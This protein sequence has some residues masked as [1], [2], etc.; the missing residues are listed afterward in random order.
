MVVKESAEE[1]RMW[2][3]AKS[4]SA[5]DGS[6][7]PLRDIF[8]LSRVPIKLA[9]A[10]VAIRTALCFLGLVRRSTDFSWNHV[11][12]LHWLRTLETLSTCMEVV[13]GIRS[14]DRGAASRA[15][16]SGLVTEKRSTGGHHAALVDRKLDKRTDG[17]VL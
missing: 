8:V 11:L 7:L 10:F 15:S 14:A 2:A 16:S 1:Q 17:G 12:T 13:R 4:A 5:D 9:L 3:G 6:I